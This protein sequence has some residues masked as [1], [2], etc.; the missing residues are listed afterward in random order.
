MAVPEGA[1]AGEREALRAEL[2]RR[3]GE[4]TSRLDL[5]IGYKGK[6]VWPH[7]SY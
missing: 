4:L 6:D 5:E 7:E 3:L 1:G 2:E